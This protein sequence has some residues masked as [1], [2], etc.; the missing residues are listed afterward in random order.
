MGV[1]PSIF[2]MLNTAVSLTGARRM[3]E[4]GN[5]HFHTNDTQFAYVDG[6]YVVKHWAEKHGIEHVSID[7][8]GADGALQ[9][10]LSKPIEG[11]EPADIV[12]NFG[13]SEHIPTNGQE[14]CFQNIFRLCKVGGIMLHALP[15]VGHW[16]SHSDVWYDPTIFD[17]SPT[18]Q[19]QLTLAKWVDEACG[20]ERHLL[21][22]V[23][24]RTSATNEEW[25]KYAA[26]NWD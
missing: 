16:K 15:P 22:A 1:T 7:L 25:M 6:D 17:W 4:L 11:I 8:N 12:T 2:A 14:Q 13:T 20:P 3:I 10:D 23:V 21:M 5:Q 26:E 18:K 19:G 9:L 24:R